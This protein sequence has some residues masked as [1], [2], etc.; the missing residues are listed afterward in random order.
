MAE[1]ARHGVAPRDDT[2]PELVHDFINDLYLY[3]IRALRKRLLDGLIPK[4]EYARH[5]EALRRR[6]PILSLPTRHWIESD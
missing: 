3:E 4:S 2:P 5:V 6:Y 1:L